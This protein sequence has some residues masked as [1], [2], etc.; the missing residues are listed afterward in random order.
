M[1]QKLKEAE[2]KFNA[3]ESRMQH[4]DAFSDMEVYAELIKEYRM[5][6]P[7]IL[8]YREYGQI[9]AQ[10]NEALEILET[11]RDAELRELA[12]EELKAQ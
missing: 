2:D 11:S 7:V 6:E 12:A 4:P 9:K 1:F 3:L 10:G 8:K 5:L